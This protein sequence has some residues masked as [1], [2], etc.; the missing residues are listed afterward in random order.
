MTMR[1][2]LPMFLCAV[3][4]FILAVPSHAAG[5]PGVE[6][7]LKI[8]TPSSPD[9]LPDGSLLIRDWPDG[10]WQ[11]YRVRPNAAGSLVA[12]DSPRE[13]LTDFPDGL[14]RYSVAPDG[15]H[16]VLMHARG[17]D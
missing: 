2:P 5:A 1:P 15:K 10:V 13:K 11:L 12:K 8:R 9:L 14:A 16:L 7:F 3:L 6:Q 17:G 4:A